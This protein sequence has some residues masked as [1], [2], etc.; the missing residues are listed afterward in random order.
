MYY[1]DQFIYSRCWNMLNTLRKM[2][3]IMKN[4]ILNSKILNINVRNKN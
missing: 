4:L 1:N 3:E 2:K